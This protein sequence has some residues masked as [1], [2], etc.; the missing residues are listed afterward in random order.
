MIRKKLLIVDIIPKV[1]AL[2]FIFYKNCKNKLSSKTKKKRKNE[3][4][5]S[6]FINLSKK[7]ETHTHT[8]T[9]TEP[10]TNSHNSALRPK[11]K[12]NMTKQTSKTR[13]DSMIDFFHKWKKTSNTQGETVIELF[14]IHF[15]L[16]Y[17]AFFLD[18]WF[19]NL[20]SSFSLLLCISHLND[21]KVFAKS[22][23]HDTF[24]HAFNQYIW[25]QHID[26]T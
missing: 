25:N 7:Y 9:Y 8:Q 20:R 24:F 26:R 5:I 12:T 1:Q 23:F 4:H 17:M 22:N 21:T 10:P 13:G 18:Q 11:T 2:I 16:T 3:E 14:P 19:V 6:Y 15:Y